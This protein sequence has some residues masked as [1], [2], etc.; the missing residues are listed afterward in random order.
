VHAQPILDPLKDYRYCGPPKRNIKG[1]I[2]RSQKTLVAF[3]KQHPCPVQRLTGVLPP[4]GTCP[5][6]AIDHVWPLADCG[7][8]AV[9]NMQWLP[10]A[11]KSCAANN[12]K[13]RWERKINSCTP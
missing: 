9:Y 11:T 1:V 3:K 4:A 5:G 10:V 12:C 13:D 6:W 8:D 2:I 7:C